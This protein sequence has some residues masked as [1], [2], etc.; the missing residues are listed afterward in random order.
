[1]AEAEAYR[2]AET[3]QTQ[4]ESDAGKGPKRDILVQFYQ[5]AIDARPGDPRN[6][7]AL[8]WIGQMYSCSFNQKAG[9]GPVWDKAA[10]AYE[11][12]L[13]TTT[14]ENC[15][16]YLS[17]WMS[18]VSIY[19][20]QGENEKAYKLV[21]PLLLLPFPD[22]VPPDYENQSAGFLNSLSSEQRKY[23]ELEQVKAGAAVNYYQL[24]CILGKITNEE[25]IGKLKFL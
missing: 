10:K 4:D 21:W 14:I 22:I 6:A 8:Y 11:E 1:M 17:A 24:S 12:L 3:A 16:K 23:L 7:P 20:Y 25:R 5:A 2:V 18:L 15:D 9:E 13:E 19:R